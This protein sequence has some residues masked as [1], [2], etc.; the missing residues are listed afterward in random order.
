MTSTYN[1]ELY[2]NE[3]YWVLRRRRSNH[4]P[5]A[6]LSHTTEMCFL[7]LLVSARGA[8]G[9]EVTPPEA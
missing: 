2:Y 7:S 5:R 8:R 9:P 4:A 6:S 3:L 1:D